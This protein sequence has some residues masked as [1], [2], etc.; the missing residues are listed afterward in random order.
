MALKSE[1]KGRAPADV[2]AR[3]KNGRGIC[4]TCYFKGDK[5]ETPYVPPR[6]SYCYFL[7]KVIRKG[8]LTTPKVV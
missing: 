5:P 7:S 1:K 6:D 4:P 3:K 8:M 2:R